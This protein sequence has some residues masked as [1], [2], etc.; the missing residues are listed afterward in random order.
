M[1]ETATVAPY[2]GDVIYRVKL[3]R[4]VRHGRVE[5]LPLDVHEIVGRV[6]N[7]IVETE[8]QDAIDSSE[9]QE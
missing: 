6:L 1:A 3:R 5:L 8:G 2:Q 9:P 4:A 7:A